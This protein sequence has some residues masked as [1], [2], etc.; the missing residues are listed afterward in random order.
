M[1]ASHFAVVRARL[2][3]DSALAGKGSDSVRVGTDGLPVRETYWVLFGGGPDE[4]D[5]GADY[6]P[7][8]ADSDAEFVYTVRLVSV[9]TDAVL[10]MLS[11]VS[12]LFAGWV[13]VV[14]G[15]SCTPVVVELGEVEPEL[16]VNPPLLFADVELSFRSSRAV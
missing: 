1:I 8:R 7:Q 4:L 12:A 9:T 13:P 2:N 10:S 15:R 6:A 16:R 11:K 14:A 5:D 3:S